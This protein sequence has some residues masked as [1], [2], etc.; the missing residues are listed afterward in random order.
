M[1]DKTSFEDIFSNYLEIQK[2]YEHSLF[3]SL[4]N[5][6]IDLLDGMLKLHGHQLI[7]FDSQDCTE[8]VLLANLIW[9]Y[10]EK[11]YIGV[12]WIKNHYQVIVQK[13]QNLTLFDERLEKPMPISYAQFVEYISHDDIYLFLVPEGIDIH[14]NFHPQIDRFQGILYGGTK[15]EVKLNFEKNYL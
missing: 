7:Y 10:E 12:I 2:D 13:Y 15:K 3:D 14:Y 9:M 4:D 11:F 1:Q 5:A 8:E 6:C